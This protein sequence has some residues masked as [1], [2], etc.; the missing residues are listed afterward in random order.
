MLKL[1]NEKQKTS[2]HVDVNIGNKT[3]SL[4]ADTGS[5]HTLLPPTHYDESIGTV[6]AADTNYEHGVAKQILK[7]SAW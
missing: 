7:S 4:F 5:D 6:V 2:K 3:F 1:S